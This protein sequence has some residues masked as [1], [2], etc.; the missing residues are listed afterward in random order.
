MAAARGGALAG[1][2]VLVTRPAHQAEGL[3]R[4]IEQ[5][6]GSARR[7]PVLEILDPLD[8]G[9]LQAVARRLDA[10][11]WAVFISANAVDRALDSILAVRDWPA[12]TRIAVIGRRSAQA[13]QHH[14]LAA[15]L[16]P[17]HKFD[18]EAL[19][20]LPDMQQV[21][22]K[23]VVIFRGDGGRELLAETLHGR[24]AQ[25]DYIE[26][27]RRARPEA[28]AAPLL[29]QWRTGAIDV[30]VVNSAESLSNLV[31]MLGESGS[32]LLRQTPLVV[33]SPRLVPLTQLLG[34]RQAPVVADNATDDAVL[35]AL[36]RWR[37]APAQ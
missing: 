27:Y 26:A 28:D 18:S 2:G 12:G 4:L 35:R 23:R 15:D 13:L 29:A 17:E 36:L 16:Y 31:D 8:P 24:G 22:G 5:Q 34:F 7:F 21:E 25:V 32:A 9:P 33:A 30:V 10:Y 14:G 19:L 11:D 3:C 20:A 37:D 1:V 6:G